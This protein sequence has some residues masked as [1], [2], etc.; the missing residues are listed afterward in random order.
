MSIPPT[1]FLR[2]ILVP[3][4]SIH[5]SILKAFRSSGLSQSDLARRAGVARSNLCEYLA[6]K[7]DTNTETADRII[8]ALA[9]HEAPGVGSEHDNLHP[10]DSPAPGA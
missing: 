5:D 2:S 9:A 7:K 6:G 8:A 10:V 3:P 4:L 1:R